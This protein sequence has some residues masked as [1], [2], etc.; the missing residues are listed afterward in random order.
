MIHTGKLEV[1]VNDIKVDSRC[2]F[3]KWFYGSTVAAKTR[4][5]VHCSRVQELHAEFH[6]TA[7][8]IAELASTGKKAAAEKLMENG[9][10]FAAL[11]SRLVGAMMKWKESV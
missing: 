6:E 5:S 3:G 10:E 4:S 1:P 11:S 2:A 7:A 8:K 9:G